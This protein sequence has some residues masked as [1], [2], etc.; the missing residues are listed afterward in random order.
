MAAQGERQLGAASRTPARRSIRLCHARQVGDRA[1]SAYAGER[2]NAEHGPRIEAALVIEYRVRGAWR[3]RQR[4][5]LIPVTAVGTLS[6]DP[7]VSIQEES[8]RMASIESTAASPAPGAISSGTW[9]IRRERDAG[10]DGNRGAWW[11]VISV[12]SI[13][14]RGRASFC[15]TRDGRLVFKHG[16]R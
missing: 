5:Q 7:D 13:W 4:F 8:S 3:S 11:P 14:D 2:F 16:A 9:I 1:D 15:V 12:R 10:A 6:S